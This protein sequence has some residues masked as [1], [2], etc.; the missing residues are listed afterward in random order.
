LGHIFGAAALGPYGGPLSG[1]ALILHGGSF[2]WPS[3]GWADKLTVNVNYGRT[4]LASDW[5]GKLAV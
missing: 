1:P 3:T 2:V 5:A 4:R